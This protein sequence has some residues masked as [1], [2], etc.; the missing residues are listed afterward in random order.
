MTQSD[1]ERD[2]ADDTEG[3][4]DRAEEG[5]DEARLETLEEVHRTLEAELDEG[6]ET[7]SA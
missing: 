7:P 3:R 1:R 4:M 2:I 5:G 6:A